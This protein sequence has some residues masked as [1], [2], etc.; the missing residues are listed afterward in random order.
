MSSVSSPEA[1]AIRFASQCDRGKVREENQDSVLR[2]SVPLGELLIVADGMG[3]FPGGGVASRMATE[4]LSAALAGMPT[5]FP[6]SIAIQEAAWRASAEIVA[7]AAEPDTPNNRMGTTVVLA[8]LQQDPEFARAV[9]AWIGH[10]GDSRAYRVHKGKLSRITR[11]HSAIQLLLE[12]N[13]I[14][15][16]EVQSHPDASVLTRTLGHEP[17]VEIELSEVVLEPGDTLL[18]CSDGLWGHVT[19]SEIERVLADPTLNTEAASRALL[20][21]ALAT[22]GHDNIGL[23]IARITAGNEVAATAEPIQTIEFV[24]ESEIPAEPEAAL[25]SV[26][27]LEPKAD[28]VIALEAALTD[29]IKSIP[30][31][32]SELAQQTKS[33]S[34]PT[35]IPE[36]DY[37]PKFESADL[38]GPSFVK[39]FT[40]LIVA[41]ASSGMLVYSALIQNWFGVDRLLH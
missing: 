31:P 14:S 4:V 34:K 27:S 37:V 28:F 13:L 25:E 35:L 24:Q 10:I 3:S 11:D 17:N 22:G 9:Q 23:Q 29:R 21:L 30:A 8:L 18:L 39:M 12:R 1:V 36:Y 2:T 38:T 32:A 7:A 41:F 15:P 5:F 33:E 16:E 19:D 6:P 26:A 40:I 20:D